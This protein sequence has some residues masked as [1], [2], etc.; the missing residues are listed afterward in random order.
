M[1][2]LSTLKELQHRIALYEDMQ[3][4]KQLYE[5]FF[6]PLHRFSYSLI[7]SKEAAEEIVSDVFIKIWQMRGELNTVASLKVYLYVITKNFSLNYITKHFKHPIISLNEISSDISVTISRPDDELISAE[8]QQKI[9]SVINDLPSQCR[10]IFQLVKEDG[11]S[12]KEV[13]SVL[14]LSTLTVRNQLAIAIKKIA[15]SLSPT[16]AS[17][18]LPAKFSVSQF[19]S[20]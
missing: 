12:Y 9:Q 15:K 19:L 20:N 7:K 4:Y 8:I 6:N 16:Q 5:L 17:Q 2:E 1:T 10:I 11:L 3:A 18:V 13:A 14:D